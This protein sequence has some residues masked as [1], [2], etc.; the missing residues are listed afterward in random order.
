M[1][2]KEEV[3]NLKK[4]L[5]KAGPYK[6]PRTFWTD[7]EGNKL[8]FK[9]FLNRWGEGMKGISQYQQIKMQLNSTYIMLVGIVCGFVI[10]LFAFENLWW[11]SI[12][13]GGALFNTGVSALGLWQK[14][15]VLKNIEDRFKEV[16]DE[17]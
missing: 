12:I 13:L 15:L 6:K 4:Q 11:L 2:T 8:T 17:K 5:K 14:K 1:E 7:K 9:E 3:K 16:E 10:T